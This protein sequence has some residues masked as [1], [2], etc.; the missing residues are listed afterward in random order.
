MSRKALAVHLSVPTALTLGV[1]AIALGREPLGAAMIA[2]YFVG[3][4]FF[5]AAPHLVWAVVASVA[6]A[7]W[8]VW[9]AGF[10]ASSVALAAIATFWTWPPDP[11]GLPLQWMLYWPLAAALQ[12][13][14]AGGTAVYRRAKKEAASAAATGA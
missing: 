2:I 11:S 13:V 7:S 4:Y 14:V 8:A 1:F 9:H 3:S 10:I 12:I 6:K 5:Y